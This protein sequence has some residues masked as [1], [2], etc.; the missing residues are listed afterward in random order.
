MAFQRLK[1]SAAPADVAVIACSS[2]APDQQTQAGLL[3]RFI[4]WI[5]QRRSLASVADGV[6]KVPNRIPP[7]P[8]VPAPWPRP[9]PSLGQ[10]SQ[11]PYAA[12]GGGWPELEQ[13]LSNLCRVWRSGQTPGVRQGARQR[14]MELLIP[15]A[16]RLAGRYHHAAT[17]LTRDDLQQEALLSLCGALETYNPRHNVPFSAFARRRMHGAILDAV[18]RWSRRHWTAT[19]ACTGTDLARPAIAVETVDLVEHL[20]AALP[21]SQRRVV[22][23][24]FVAEMPRSS[25]AQL[26]G[27]HVSR[28]GQLLREAIAALRAEP[29]TDQLFC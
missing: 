23:L 10:M 28:V 25:I 12:F 18:R 22:E 3:G 15:M 17:G 29:H 27:V 8:Q 24:H 2:H 7:I 4:G 21:A 5:R 26:L 13:E 14:V 11:Q 9:V 20:L 19:A 16:A 6:P 1:D